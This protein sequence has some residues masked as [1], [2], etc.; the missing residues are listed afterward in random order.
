VRVELLPNVEFMK[1][2]PPHIAEQKRLSQYQQISTFIFHV[3]NVAQAG[4]MPEKQA[5][6]IY[7]K[8]LD[9]Y[10]QLRGDAFWLF[11]DE[12]IRLLVTADSFYEQ[13][14]QKILPDLSPYS[15]N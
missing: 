2:P 14:G 7:K 4:G 13:S 3:L 15:R 9:A 1:K 11:R 5:Q 6:E 8:T 12:I 10:S